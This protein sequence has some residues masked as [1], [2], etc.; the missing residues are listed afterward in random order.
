MVEYSSIL[1]SRLILPINVKKFIQ[2]AYTRNADALVLDLEDSIPRNKKEEARELITEALK[3]VSKSDCPIYIRVNADKEFLYKDIEKSVVKGVTGIV[4]PKVESSNDVL[5]LEKWITELEK[6]KSLNENS[7]T[8]SILIET[9][10]GFLNMEEIAQSS[11]RI[12]SISLGMEDLAEDMGFVI[13][14]NT[15]STLNYMRMKLVTVA[16]AYNILPLGLTGSIAN[17]TN[18]EK[19]KEDAQAAFELGF[20]GS[21]CIHP[22]QVEILNTAFNY[23]DQEVKEA[24]EIIKVFNNAVENN[25]ASA[26]YK[27]KMIDYPHYEKAIKII[28]KNQAVIKYEEKKAETRIKIKGDII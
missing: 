17:F 1:R 8:I 10:K 21:S 24:E 5:T 22:N 26:T 25:R 15:N 20:V 14:E 6:E 2:K 11:T 7:V 13:N 28:T 4:L 23:T 3:H 18:L 12:E 9:A 16:K 19:L 27:G